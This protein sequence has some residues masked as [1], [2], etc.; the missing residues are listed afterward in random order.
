MNRIC[1]AC[2][3]KIHEKSYLKQRTICKN[4]HNRNRRKNNHTTII[5]NEI[6][7]S[8]Q[9]PKIDNVSRN[10]TNVPEKRITANNE[11]TILFRNT[12]IPET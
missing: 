5:K 1:N 11:T 2:G 6:C 12:T 3:I 7:T 8:Q 10:K 9:Q 4:C